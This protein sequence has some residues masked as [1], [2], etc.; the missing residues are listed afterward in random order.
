M[1]EVAAS[2]FIWALA[3]VAMVFVDVAICINYSRLTPALLLV[4][5]TGNTCLYIS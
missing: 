4:G 1:H 2:I 3:K 5:T